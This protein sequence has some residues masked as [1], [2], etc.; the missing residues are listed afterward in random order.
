MRKLFPHRCQKAK[1][2]NLKEKPL[3]QKAGPHYVLFEA[4]CMTFTTLTKG[5][6]LCITL[7]RV[8]KEFK[9]FPVCVCSF[10][11]K[12]VWLDCLHVPKSIAHLHIF[13]WQKQVPSQP[14]WYCSLSK[15]LL[16]NFRVKRF[17]SAANAHNSPQG[18]HYW[19]CPQVSV[20]PLATQF[21][22]DPCWADPLAKFMQLQPRAVSTGLLHFFKTTK[23]QKRGCLCESPKISLSVATPYQKDAIYPNWDCCFK[24]VHFTLLHW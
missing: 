18:C 19:W 1:G 8:L 9:Q 20:R 14:C 23:E 16:A 24:V 12:V 22:D 15:L 4:E 6:R 17:N 7:I 2:G 11:Q 21:L 10:D 5:S 13:K 3:T